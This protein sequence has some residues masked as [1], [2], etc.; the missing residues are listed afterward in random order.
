MLL[1]IETLIPETWFIPFMNKE[2]YFISFLKQTLNFT[3][4]DYTFI[5]KYKIMIW[6][7]YYYI[8]GLI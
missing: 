7:L 1:V 5:I 8:I 4:H 6:S 3:P 2:K